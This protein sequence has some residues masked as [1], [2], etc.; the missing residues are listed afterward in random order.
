M[1]VYTFMSEYI[2][3]KDTEHEEMRQKIDKMHKLFE[4][5]KKNIDVIVTILEEILSREEVLLN[6]G[7]QHCIGCSR[8]L[9]LEEQAFL[10]HGN[11]KLEP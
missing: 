9:S 1:E 7:K 6:A 4:S 11:T 8:N 3:E 5:A 2:A 10:R